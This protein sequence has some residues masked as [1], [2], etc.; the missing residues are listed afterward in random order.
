MSDPNS[1]SSFLSSFLTHHSLFPFPGVLS[2]ISLDSDDESDD[3]T[4]HREALIDLPSNIANF[5]PVSG[6][7]SMVCTGKVDSGQG[8]A[9]CTRMPVSHIYESNSSLGE[10][11]GCIF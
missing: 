7:G 4:M 3:N 2:P 1:V 6:P 9:T 5:D 11:V 8:T 10:T